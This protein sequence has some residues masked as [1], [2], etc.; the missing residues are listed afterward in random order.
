MKEQSIYRTFA[1]YTALNVLGMIGLSCYI[2]AD[3]FFVSQALG[4][5]G[6][7]ALNLAIPVYSFI[8]GMGLMI[9]MGGATRFAIQKERDDGAQSNAIFTRAVWFGLAA[10]LLFVLIGT[11]FSGPLASLLGADGGVFEMTRVYLQ[12]ILLFSPMFLLNNIL[13][14]F[15]RND[16]NPKLSML[17]M[18]IGSLSNVVLD[19][20]FLFPLGMGIFGAVLA[21]G[22][23]PVIGILILSLHFIGK[24]S[25]FR[26][27]KVPFSLTAVRD[28]I[29]LG[30]ASLV[31]E[32]SSGTVMIVFN[33][34]IL[35]LKGDIG[36]AAYGV[37]ANLSLVILSVFTG[38]AQGIQPIVSQNYGAGNRENVKKALNC[39]RI[40]AF[41]SAAAVY[42]VSVLFADPIVGLFNRDGSAAL[43]SIAVWGIILYFSGF[44]FAGNNVITAV[45]LGSVEQ[46]RFS[47]GLSFLRGFL[48][49]IPLVVLLAWPFG[50]TGV[51][52]AFPITELISAVVAVGML[53]KTR[54]LESGMNLPA[55]E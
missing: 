45:Y 32:F 26:I 25:S 47:F 5:S 29:R 21:T 10:A 18:L 35:R 13:L 31:A 3:T 43:A 2:L 50:M 15:V 36:V 42:A 16:G 28:T 27:C 8:N 54:R 9:G 51:W 11:F 19:Y 39:G 1:K 17:A 52:L 6:L 38:I 40:T 53:R 14:C 33:M 12:V 30:S 7:T 41:V 4:S 44:L 20:I 34:V 55:G 46:A 37:V 22:C 23:A 48:L 24:K 49:I